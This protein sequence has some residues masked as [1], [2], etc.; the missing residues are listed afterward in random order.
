MLYLVIPML[1]GAVQG[2]RTGEVWDPI[3]GDQVTALRDADGCLTEAERLIRSA[4]ALT[5]LEAPWEEKRR[6]WTVR[7]QTQHPDVWNMLNI[8]RNNLLKRANVPTPE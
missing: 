6:E 8:S 4:S 7:C 2:V 5:R 1:I 3:T